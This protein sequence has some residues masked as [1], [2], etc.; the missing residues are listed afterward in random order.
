MLVQVQKPAVAPPRRQPIWRQDGAGRVFRTFRVAFME[1]RK[2][3]CMTPISKV[4][5]AYFE[6]RSPAVTWGDRA[7]R[8][9][10]VH[11]LPLGPLL[12]KVSKRSGARGF[13]RR[14]FSGGLHQLSKVNRSNNARGPWQR[15]WLTTPGEKRRS[16]SK[17]RQ[18]RLE[19]G[20]LCSFRSATGRT[21]FH[22]TATLM[23]ANSRPITVVGDQFNERLD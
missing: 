17:K 14:P 6:A 1:S 15:Q 23:K 13:R 16:G 12:G 22:P 9:S 2:L 10:L 18:E 21:I 4:Y 7:S 20:A 5:Q 19:N 11:N 8:L 3:N